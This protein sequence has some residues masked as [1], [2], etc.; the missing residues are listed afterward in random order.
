MEQRTWVCDREISLNGKSLLKGE[1]DIEMT[2]K[3]FSAFSLPAGYAGGNLGAQGP[4]HFSSKS[5]NSYK[6]TLL[7]GRVCIWVPLFALISAF[8][9]YHL[10]ALL[11][12]GAV[13]ISI[14][15]GLGGG[16]GGAVGGVIQ[17]LTMMWLRTAMNYQYRNGG[18][19]GDTLRL[20]HS[21]GG[22]GRFYQGIGFALLQAPLSRFG[23]TF[24][25]V[26]VLA[27][28]SS[29]APNVAISAQTVVATAATSLWRLALTPLDMFKTTLQVEGAIAYGLLLRKVEEV[30][31]GRDSTSHPFRFAANPW[32]F[33]VT[34]SL[35]LQ[36]GPAVL[37]NGAL[38]NAVASFVGS[39]PW[40]LTVNL[41]DSRLPP[42]N[43]VVRA[44]IMGLVSTCV[45]DVLSNS[46]RVLKTVKQTAKKNISYRQG[47]E[48]RGAKRRCCA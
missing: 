26:A 47:V 11:P 5:T 21:E 3:D 23:N 6:L 9:C 28:F 19:L 36:F 12:P 41:L 7:T 8:V 32:Y 22:I 44:A 42:F 37:W 46:I 13:A 2:H 34:C 39:Y 35:S 1:N 43:L 20:L 27:M 48:W 31:T 40:F 38:G 45:S 15:K 17:V 14:R 33:F 24:A 4:S 30:R 29:F 10:F 18:T 16:V 25:N